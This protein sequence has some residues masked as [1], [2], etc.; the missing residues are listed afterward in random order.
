MINMPA[1]YLL[2]NGFVVILAGL[3]LGFPLRYAIIKKKKKLV[4]AWRVAHSVS[5]M[6]GLMMIIVGL[7]IPHLFL[8]R[9]AIWVLVWS[10][11]LSGYGFVMA[12]TI[13][14]WKGLRGLTPKPY[15]LNTILFVAHII[16]ALGSLVGVLITIYGALRAIL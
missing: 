6:D 9:L 2:F 13:G 11:V 12:F 14:A 7:T 1:V 15:G 3:L 10:L 4:N 16:G 5:I 8:D